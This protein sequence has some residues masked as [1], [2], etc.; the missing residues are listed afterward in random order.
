MLLATP[1]FHDL[2]L[3]NEAG[4]LLNKYRQ[5]QS[6]ADLSQAERTL[7][8]YISGRQ[9]GTDP[10]L[11][12]SFYRTFGAV[13]SARRPTSYEYSMLAQGWKHG[14][15]DRTG[16]LWLGEVASG[17]GNWP[18]A[19][20]AYSEV[21]ATNL[22]VYRGDIAAAE[23]RR[24]EAADWYRMAQA[25]LLG[26]LSGAEAATRSV[27][28]GPGEP[29]IG[30]LRIGRGFLALGRA[31][32][33]R[34]SLRLAL[35]YMN[36]DPPGPRDQQS[37]L[38]GLAEAEIAQREGDDPLPAALVHECEKL[39]TTA[40]DVDRS[41]WSNLK[42]GQLRLR[43]GLRGAAV[44]SFRTALHLDPLLTEAYMS[45]GQV[46]EEDGLPSLARDLYHEGLERSPANRELA[47]AHAKASFLTMSASTALPLLRRSVE[48][49]SRDPFVFAFLGDC[50]REANDLQGARHAYLS[51]LRFTPGADALLERLERIP[52]PTGLAP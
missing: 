50:L 17:T 40:L 25:S 46:F 52:R 41:A 4:L 42:A 8:S 14:R 29:A 12:A 33:A 15:L 19:R 34:K 11:H 2:W 51:G 13:A 49:G 28:Q 9:S 36:Q 21:D 3:I 1:L 35:E 26:R 44:E 23:G 38:F 16:T 6:L 43:S 37:I 31:E 18:T 5:T 39:L 27:P 22:L 48:M 32:E 45:L 7:E 47:D 20:Q 30:L 24:D 10:G